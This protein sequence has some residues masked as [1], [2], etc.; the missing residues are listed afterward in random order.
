MDIILASIDNKIQTLR[1]SSYFSDL[2]HAALDQL[3]HGMSLRRYDSGEV[4]FWQGDPCQG[5]WMIQVGT[6]KLFKL[7]PRGRELILHTL[8]TGAVFNEVP[9]FDGGTN[10]INVAA[11]EEV[12]LWLVERE[13][14]LNVMQAYPE[15]CH[16]V[17]VNLAANLRLLVGK[18][19]E[20][21]FLQVTN[22]LAR[23]L[24][25]L[26]GSHDQP[27]CLEGI[28][29]DQLAARLG[30]VREVVARALRD[31]ELSG[32]IRVKRRQIYIL[33][34]KLLENWAQEVR[35]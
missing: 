18:V 12:E 15:L 8:N 22:R 28:T 17:V 30:T 32:A 10:P 6:V 14:I 7:S 11:L 23:L 29:Q 26:P 20:L 27:E 16:S 13:T 4:I 5:L 33:N 35:V 21:S 3:A 24:N 1:A 34:K 9:V 31:L 25:Q 19:E 2:P